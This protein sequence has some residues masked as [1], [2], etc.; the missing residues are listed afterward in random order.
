VLFNSFYFILIFLPI[1]L[2]GYFFLSKTQDKKNL[3]FFLVLASLFFYGYWKI[4]YLL[5]ILI[6]VLINF[7]IS[8]KIINKKKFFFIISILTNIGILFFFK[9]IDFFIFN[10]N[11][12]L[13]LNINY[14]NI[15]LPLAISFFSLQQLAYII[16]TK[17]GINKNKSFIDYIF[18]VT[19][20]PQ[21]IAGPIVLFKEV[22]NQINKQENFKFNYKNFNLGLFVFIIGLSKKILIADTIGVHVDIGYSNYLDINLIEG[23]ILTYSYILQLYFDISGYADMAI[24]LALLFNIK[25]PINFNSPL[26]QRNLISFWQNWHIT[27][28]RFITAYIYTPLLIA[29]RSFSFSTAMYVTLITMTIAGLWHG[30]SWC[31]IIF[32]F[33]HGLGLIINH[34]FIKLNFKI[35]YLLSWFITF[36]Y[37]N[38]TLI[39]FRSEKID[40]AIHIIKSMFG[41]NKIMLPGSLEYLFYFSQSKIEFGTYLYNLGTDNLYYFYL[42]VSFYILFFCKNT[43]QLQK[44][45]NNQSI[46]LIIIPILFVLCIIN[47]TDSYRFIYF[48]F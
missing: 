40:Q 5:L 8:L 24:G 46:N 20:F 19:F 6:S 12:I 34:I 7:Y 1:V 48:Q 14:L 44:Q 47:M 38:F 27:L 41:L 16:D 35:H 11:Y 25:L 10:L 15:T 30:A 18:F 31:F 32:G 9:Y 3:K 33:L 13:H 17:Q 2:A 4:E 43:T 22:R 45:F 23:W 21:L 37:I 42:F 28:T 29:F 36:N 39:F 26:K